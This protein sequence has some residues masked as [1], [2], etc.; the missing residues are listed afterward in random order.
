MVA[1]PALL[2]TPIDNP[3]VGD[4]KIA[5][6]FQ[7]MVTDGDRPHIFI[8]GFYDDTQQHSIIKVGQH[9]AAFYSVPDHTCLRHVLREL[10]PGA[11]GWRFTYA[12][13]ALEGPAMPAR[14]LTEEILALNLVNHLKRD[15][16]AADF[17][18]VVVR[19]AAV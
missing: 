11:V 12:Q 15:D 17:D 6:V 5:Q 18:V 19:E 9:A 7:M 8:Y 10:F 4:W 3:F 1:P 13:W 16:N 14:N 2:M